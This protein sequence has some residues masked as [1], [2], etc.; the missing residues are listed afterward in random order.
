MKF[1]EAKS[2]LLKSYTHMYC[3]CLHLC[4]YIRVR[5]SHYSDTIHIQHTLKLKYESTLLFFISGKRSQFN[6]IDFYFL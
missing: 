3:S 1:F 6:D 5:T 4:M 2:H